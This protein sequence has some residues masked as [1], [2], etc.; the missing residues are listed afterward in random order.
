MA[1]G[2]VQNETRKFVMNAFFDDATMPED[3]AINVMSK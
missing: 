1:V 3:F 2:L